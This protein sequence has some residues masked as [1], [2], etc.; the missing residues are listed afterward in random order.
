M[1]KALSKW[2]KSSLHLRRRVSEP[3]CRRT[4]D[5]Q[6]AADHNKLRKESLY[7]LEMVKA[8]DG[9]L[10]RIYTVRFRH[11]VLLIDNDD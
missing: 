11:R 7:D 10:H 6:S 8:S 5:L 1:A 4:S 2:A 3:N 9:D